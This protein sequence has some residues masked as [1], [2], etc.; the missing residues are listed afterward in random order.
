MGEKE[1]PKSSEPPP[2][3][4]MPR[5]A[6]WTSVVP[7]LV[8]LVLSVE[9]MLPSA[10]QDFDVLIDPRPLAIGVALSAF[11]ALLLSQAPRCAAWL[12]PLA[13]LPSLC[14]WLVPAASSV[15]R[16]Y[17]WVSVPEPG[18]GTFELAA[19]GVHVDG[20][21][22]D[23]GR[24]ERRRPRRGRAHAMHAGN[25][26]VQARHGTDRRSPLRRAAQP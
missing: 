23:R 3:S 18:A 24:S 5:W 19:R 22:P 4:S 21:R 12:Y 17:Y 2:E 20:S 14:V 8:G 16:T 25:R 15:E 1:L 9:L 10:T 26:K 7:A 13:L 6:V 11:L